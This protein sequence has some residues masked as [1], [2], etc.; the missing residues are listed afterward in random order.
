MFW[1]ILG[2][3]TPTQAVPLEGSGQEG[4]ERDTERGHPAGA[5]GLAGTGI[6]A[7]GCGAQCAQSIPDSAV[8]CAGDSND[9][10]AVSTRRPGAGAVRE[11]ANGA[12]G[13]AGGVG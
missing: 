11:K 8:R 1:P 2:Y 13:I 6:A 12:R 10:Q 5:R 4:T 3:G 9:R 7:T